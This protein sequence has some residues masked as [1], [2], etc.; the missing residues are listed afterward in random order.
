MKLDELES[1][2]MVITSLDMTII[3][4]LILPMSYRIGSVIDAVGWLNWICPI[5]SHTHFSLSCSKENPYDRL[6]NYSSSRIWLGNC[7]RTVIFLNVRHIYKE[8]KLW[9]F[10]WSL[11]Q[12]IKHAHLA[13]TEINTQSLMKANNLERWRM[14]TTIWIKTG[15]TS[16]HHSKSYK[17]LVLIWLLLLF[18]SVRNLGLL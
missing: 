11:K 1:L 9:I 10:L 15:S 3:A 5:Q 17:H 14:T 12:T 4:P 8:K 6:T 18:S 7:V 2:L 13:D 16:Q